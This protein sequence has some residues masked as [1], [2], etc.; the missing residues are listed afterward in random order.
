MILKGPCD[1]SSHVPNVSVKKICVSCLFG[2]ISC[3][4]P[5]ASGCV[6]V[7]LMSQL[8]R[9]RA[10]IHPTNLERFTVWWTLLSKASPSLKL[11]C[12]CTIGLL[13]ALLLKWDSTLCPTNYNIV[14][15]FSS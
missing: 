2:G 14:L 13:T 15:T 3:P 12:A 10:L 7:C 8:A 5:N 6:W 11:V 4:E 9:R 1:V